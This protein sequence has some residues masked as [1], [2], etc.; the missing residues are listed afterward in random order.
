MSHLHRWIPSFQVL[1]GHKPLIPIINGKTL[2]EIENPRL[3]RLKMKMG[4]VGPFVAN[5][6]PGPQHKAAD[7]LSRSLIQS[8]TAND[9][10]GEYADVHAARSALIAVLQANH[11]DLLLDHMR[12]ATA[13][14][15][16]LQMLKDAVVAGFPSS[17]A[18]IAE[19]SRK[20]WPVRD[21][22]SVDD[23]LILCGTRVVVP[24]SLRRSTMTSLHASHL[25]KEKQKS[26]PAGWSS[27]REWAPVSMT[28]S[29]D[30]NG[31]SASF[32]RTPG[33]PCC[34]TNLLTTRSRYWTWISRTTQEDST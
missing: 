26:A 6:V 11:T 34:T 20:Y 33:R 15:P 12:S 9:A 23:G 28:S 5:W 4:E 19:P 17:K 8:T 10:C 27:G 32:P 7:A 3:Q 21:R 24:A 18:D 16:E 2:D 14:D 22:L 1:T 13:E 30:A 31:V 29:K 25:G